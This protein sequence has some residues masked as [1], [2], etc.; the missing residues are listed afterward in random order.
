MPLASHNQHPPP[1]VLSS[2]RVST[3]RVTW[4]P[5]GIGSRPRILPLACTFT[6]TTLPIAGSEPEPYGV[7]L[8]APDGAPQ[9]SVRPPKLAWER[10]KVW[11]SPDARQ[12][13]T[14]IRRAA[15]RAPELL[16]WAT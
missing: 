8:S 10:A 16:D 12:S 1:A 5:L 4:P 9:V 3:T 15:S 14:T 13:P 2:L 11:A 7:T 6:R